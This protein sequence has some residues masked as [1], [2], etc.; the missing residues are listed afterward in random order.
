MLQLVDVIKRH[1]LKQL[2]DEP[3]ALRYT[4]MLLREGRRTS[5]SPREETT[6]R[7][8]GAWKTEADREHYESEGGGSPRSRI[9]RYEVAPLLADDHPEFSVVEF[10]ETRHFAKRFPHTRTW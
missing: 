6:V 5:S 9:F 3:A 4:V 10:G 7:W 1:A 2:I 8:L